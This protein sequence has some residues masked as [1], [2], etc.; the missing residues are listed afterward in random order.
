MNNMDFKFDITDLV[1][2]SFPQINEVKKDEDLVNEKRIV[3][4]E[5]L[6]SVLYVV[7]T[8]I[9]MIS[10]TC[11]VLTAMMHIGHK[12]I[13]YII[14]GIVFIICVVIAFVSPRIFDEKQKKISYMY[15]E[16]QYQYMDCI[17]HFWENISKILKKETTLISF[18][19]E[20]E[21]KFLKVSYLDEDGKLHS[22]K[23]GLSNNNILFKDVSNFI[24]DFDLPKDHSIP[25]HTCVKFTIPQKY[26]KNFVGQLN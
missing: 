14:F 15:S 1:I 6:R 23:F 11:I 2:N 17:K 25:Y 7:L 13:L 3:H 24:I 20:K 4:L 22:E 10:L 21:D 8:L 16:A 12:Y 5:H 19:K 9:S 18:I 26:Y